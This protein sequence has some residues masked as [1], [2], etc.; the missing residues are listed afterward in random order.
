MLKAVLF[1]LDNTLIH[2]SE[3]RFF[4]SYVPQISRVFSDIM[5][6]DV[7]IE[8]LLLSTQALMKN[9]GGKSNAEYFLDVF[10]TGLEEH[11]ERIW[12]RFMRFYETDYDQ[13]RALV[14]V[15][16]DVSRV[17]LELRNK[18]VK[19]VIASN[20][21]WPLRAQMKRL[22][23]AGLGH[24]QFD[25]ATHIEN[26]SYCKPRIEYYQE[27]CFKIGQRPETCLMV[28]NDPVNDMVV[29]RI[30]M[31]TFLVTDPLKADEA[32]LELSRSVR[33]GGVLDIPKPDFEGPL[34]E[35]PRAVDSLLRNG[36][37]GDV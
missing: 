25:L 7:L 9:N 27:I 35:V 12:E 4:E 17:F 14:S 2:F 21:I 30:G 19:L 11:R 36:V 37:G 10:C 1:D 16:A 6:A 5:P 31:R 24:L 20:P 15:P 32:A 3:R 34:S 29:A 18:A 13:F 28:G 22:S 8:R 23:W 26:M 33:S